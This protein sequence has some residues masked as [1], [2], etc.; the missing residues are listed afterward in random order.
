MEGK[1]AQRFGYIIIAFTLFWVPMVVTLLMNIISWHE[2]DRFLMELETSAMVLTCVPAAVDPLIYTMV[3]R[4][5]RSEFSK[6]LS[7]IRGCPVKLRA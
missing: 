1:L 2:T 7:S 6:I 3:T 5:F 4:Q